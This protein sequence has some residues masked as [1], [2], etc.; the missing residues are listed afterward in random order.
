METEKECKYK[1]LILLIEKRQNLTTSFIS[2]FALVWLLQQIILLF[3]ICILLD[4]LVF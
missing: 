4:H 1:K 2:I 3:L